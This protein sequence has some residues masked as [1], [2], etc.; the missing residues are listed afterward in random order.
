MQTNMSEM[1]SAEYD[2]ERTAVNLSLHEVG[3]RDCLVATDLIEDDVS[4]F[5]EV[6]DA[7]M[8]TEKDESS[9]FFGWIVTSLCPVVCLDVHSSI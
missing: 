9:E 2:H 6:R 4:G 7:A 3:L 8:A 5:F 1:T